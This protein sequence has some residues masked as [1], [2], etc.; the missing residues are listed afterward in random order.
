MRRWMWWLCVAPLALA[1]CYHDD[2]DDGYDDGGHWGGSYQTGLSFDLSGVQD[3]LAS[4]APVTIKACFDLDCDVLTLAA[5]R[6][7]LR[8][9]GAPGGPPDQLTGCVF[10]RS[11]KLRV[12]IV[13]VDDVNYGDGRAHT[14]AIAITDASGQRVL[15]HAEQVTYSGYESELITITP[16]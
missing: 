4:I 10:S 15:S 8:C 13:R 11:G 1:G 5:D 9:E 3:A 14:A 6:Q 12:N 2:S 16:R 7:G